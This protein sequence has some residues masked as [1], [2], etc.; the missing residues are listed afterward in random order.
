MSPTK[1]LAPFLILFSFLIATNVSAQA[2]LESALGIASGKSINQNDKT[3]QG[4]APNQDVY[5]GTPGTYEEFIFYDKQCKAQSELACLK[6]ANIMMSQTPPQ[7]IFD[8]SFS[9]R[10]ERALR[11]YEIAINKGN[12]E[13]ME[14]AYDLYYDPYPLQR[15]INSYTDT[16]RAKELME[17]MLAKNYSGGLARQAKDYIEN[18]E[19]ALSI[20]KKTLACKTIRSL[21]NSKNLTVPTKAIVDNLNS[22]IVCRVIN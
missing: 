21:E 20:E 13:A 12:L 15:L 8:L 9:R 2:G 1:Y 3:P 17:T 10:A 11:L 7:Q 4:G 6:A 5:L 18:P 14:Y 16:S 22:S 19:Y